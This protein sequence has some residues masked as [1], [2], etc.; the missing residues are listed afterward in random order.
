MHIKRLN[1]LTG[2]PKG[3]SFSIRASA[4]VALPLTKWLHDYLGMVPMAI[5]LVDRNS[6]LG[7]KMQ[8]ALIKRNCARAL[9]S[10]SFFKADCVFA[11][12]ATLASLATTPDNWAGIELALPSLGHVD[13]VE[14]C[15]LG[16]T[17]SLHIL[18]LLLNALI[19]E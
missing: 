3:A 6:A 15:V 1:S 8:Q 5:D 19:R 7:A 16:A 14:K 10:D 12:G 17:G 9:D 11:D 2:L 13:I 4:S 18:E